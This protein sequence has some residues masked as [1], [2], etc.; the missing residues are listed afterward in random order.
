MQITAV[1]PGPHVC[2]VISPKAL[3][4]IHAVSKCIMGQGNKKWYKQCAFCIKSQMEGNTHLMEPKCVLPV[5]YESTAAPGPGT[6]LST[7]FVYG[8]CG[9]YEHISWEDGR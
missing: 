3:V 8:K 7:T 1:G 5:V 6:W 2:W 4:K 9:K